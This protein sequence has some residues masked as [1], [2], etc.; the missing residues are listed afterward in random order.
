MSC[1]YVDWLLAGSF[2]Q[3]V[4]INAWHIPIAVY[5]EMYLLMMSSKPDRNM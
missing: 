5:T 3:P 2:Q 1:I 4:N